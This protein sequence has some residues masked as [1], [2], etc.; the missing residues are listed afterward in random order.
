[1]QKAK[2]NPQFSRKS[3]LFGIYYPEPNCLGFAIP[4][5]KLTSLARVFRRITRVHINL[6]FSERNSKN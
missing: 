5:C 3:M 2:Y 4:I 1:M 6:P